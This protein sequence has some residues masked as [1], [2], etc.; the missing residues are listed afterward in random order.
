MRSMRTPGVD[1]FIRDNIA[2]NVLYKILGVDNA[3][4]IDLN[5]TIMNYVSSAKAFG[6]RGYFVRDKNFR[7]SAKGLN[8]PIKCYGLRGAEG[9]VERSEVSSRLE[10]IDK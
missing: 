6:F 3:K 10:W 2:V 8:E 5:N 9:Y 1:I 7:P 4:E